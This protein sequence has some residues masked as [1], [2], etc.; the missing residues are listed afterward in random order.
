M[1]RYRDSFTWADMLLGSRPI[2]LVYA[3][4]CLQKDGA[5][6]LHREERQ[7]RKND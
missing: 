1:K 5:I 4:L 3:R 6:A 2:L 7:T